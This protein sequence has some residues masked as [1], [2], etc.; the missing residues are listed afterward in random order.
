MSPAAV[1]PV[2]SLDPWG[3]DSVTLGVGLIAVMLLATIRWIC[4]SEPVFS[5]RR[6]ITDFLHGSVIYPFALLMVSVPDIQIFDHLRN[7][8]LVLG[9][10]GGVGIFFVVGELITTALE[11]GG[12]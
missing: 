1:P 7:S 8:R 10:A 11:L 9:L 12:D 6:V 5:R 2:V 4:K 3:I